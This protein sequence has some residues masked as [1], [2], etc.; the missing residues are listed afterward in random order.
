MSTIRMLAATHGLRDSR[1]GDPRSERSGNPAL[2]LCAPEATSEYDAYAGTVGRLLREGAREEEITNFL[3]EVEEE[4]ITLSGDAA[5]AAHKIVEW[6]D[7]V[8]TQLDRR[9]P[10]A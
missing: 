2:S 9:D 3:R 10:L 6:H 7:R 1:Y 8:M 5:N 4:R